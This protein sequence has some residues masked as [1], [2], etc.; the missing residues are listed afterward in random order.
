MAIKAEVICDSVSEVGKRLTTFSLVM[1]RCILPEFTRHRAFSLSVGSSRAILVS[2]IVEQVKEDP[3]VPLEWGINQPG[4]VAT[5]LAGAREVELGEQCWLQARDRAVESAEELVGLGFHK[6][7]VNRLLEPW[8]WVRVICSA[9]E[10]SNFYHLRCAADAE[11]HLQR[12]ACAMRDAME[13]S[14]PEPRLRGS[15]HLP[16]IVE[17]DWLNAVAVGVPSDGW[18]MAAVSA[19]RCA[20]V[21]YHREDR[22]DL[23]KDWERGRGLRTSG[24]WSPLEHQAAPANNPD[25]GSGN[26]EGWFQH[27]HWS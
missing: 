8:M 17:E 11:P 1:P 26:F 6:Q 20:A 7:I 12:L 18:A 23:R 14:E 27:R 25:V 2:R 16:Y 21:S 22:Q 4:M 15:L 13:A 24:H 5:K 3:F 19:G 9:T 10:W